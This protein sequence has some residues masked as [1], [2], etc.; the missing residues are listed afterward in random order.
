M[1]QIQKYLN[2]NSLPWLLEKQD[3]SVY[4]VTSRDILN[5]E[6]TDDKYKFLLEDSTIQQIL[7]NSQERIIG[8]SDN[9]D[10]F[11]SGSLWYFAVAVEYGLDS[12]TEEIR[13]TA[14]F[15]CTNSI[16]DGGGFSFNWKPRTAVACRTGDM[17]R[18]L[19]RSGYHGDSVPSGI[20]WILRH[21]RHDGG[22]LHCPLQGVCDY[23][24]FLLFNKPG[25][26][27]KREHDRS[28]PSCLIATTA[29]SYALVE[30]RDRFRDNGCNQAI[31]DASRFILR[32]EYDQSEKKTMNCTT[33]AN[34]D[35]KLLGYPILS[36][37]DILYGLIYLARSGFYS[38]VRTGTLFNL[39]ISKQNGNGTWNLENSHTGMLFGDEKKPPLGR[40]NKWVT[41][42]VFRLLTSTKTAM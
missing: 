33:S 7:D 42:N 27:L 6:T 31:E 25:G 14:E 17:V 9:F 21:Q 3:R 23:T 26:G 37:F 19:I 34:T 20:Q 41:L 16:T 18:Y 12:R 4:Y 40:M 36:Q 30:Y 22:W 29:C 8:D 2:R 24:R 13:E 1:E 10:I 32:Y 35:F 38:D 39:I 15:L 5:E 11:Y 28:I